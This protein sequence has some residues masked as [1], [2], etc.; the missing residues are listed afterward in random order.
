MSLFEDDGDDDVEVEKE[1]NEDEEEP[2]KKT[3]Q[4]HDSPSNE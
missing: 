4:L 2:G 3:F 1:E